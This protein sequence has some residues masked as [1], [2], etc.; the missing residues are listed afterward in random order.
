MSLFS[1][2][3]FPIVSWSDV[4]PDNLTP[5][6]FITNQTSWFGI[7]FLIEFLALA[8][9]VMFSVYTWRMSNC[10][11]IIPRN[12]VNSSFSFVLTKNSGKLLYSDSSLYLSCKS[13]S[14]ALLLYQENPSLFWKSIILVG[15]SSGG[16]IAVPSVYSPSSKLSL[17]R[18]AWFA[19]P[20]L[21]LSV[22]E[23]PEFR[24]AVPE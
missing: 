23:N 16:N 22:A 1:S 10:S 9:S 8:I 18:D 20:I 4:L 11:P 24:F 15:I 5:N 17:N 2:N 13:A 19:N 12:R 14:F 7:P 6:E 3:F 21:L